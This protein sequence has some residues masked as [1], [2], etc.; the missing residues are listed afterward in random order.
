MT[1][2]K[3]SFHKLLLKAKYSFYSAVVFFLFANPETLTILQKA[4][5]TYILFSTSSGP[6]ISGIFV[7]T[8]LF[9]LTMLGLML[10]P[11]N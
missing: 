3:F 10:L 11:E 4:F 5:G 9:F 2:E 6:T 7:L 8:I 1:S